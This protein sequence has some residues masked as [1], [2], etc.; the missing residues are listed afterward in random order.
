ME[1]QELSYIAGENAKWYSHFGR[2]F[3]GFL[4]NYTYFYHMIQ[5]S[6]SLVFTQKSCLYKILHTDVYS[7]FTH[8][9]Q[10]L[11][12]NKMFFSR[13]MNKCT[14]RQ[15]NIISAKKKYAIKLWKDMR[16]LK[17]ILLIER[18]SKKATHCVIPTIWLSGKVKL[19]WQLKRSVGSS[20]VA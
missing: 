15:Q 4:Q 10:H 5:Q 13:W 3:G 17:Y 20:L 18:K 16:N 7:S 19:W 8:N 6:H 2:Q 12:A 9:C 14:S 1:Q 11:L